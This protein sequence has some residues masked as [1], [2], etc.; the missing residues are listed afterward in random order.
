MRS[1]KLQFDPALIREIAARYEYE[2]DNRVIE[3]GDRARARGWFTR[4]EFIE[5]GEWKSP[6]IRSR[7]AR[8]T[9]EDVRT[10]TQAALAARDPASAINALRILHGVEK[11]VASVFLHLA[12]PDPYPILD[13]RALDA[14]GVT[15]RPP[16]PMSLWL[17]YVEETRRLARDCRVDM[18]TLDR[19]LWQWSRERSMR[20]RASGLRRTGAAA[21]PTRLPDGRVDVVILGCVSSKR[22]QPGP[23]KDLYISPLWHK[24]RAYA[25]ASGRP[26][27]IYSAKHGILAP[28]DPIEWYDVALMKRPRTAQRA[29]GEQAAAQLEERFG[30]LEGKVFEIHAGSAYA[31]SLE[32]PLRRR[33]AFLVNPVIGLSI[34]YQ[35]QWYGQQ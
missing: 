15:Q 5:I 3:L 4:D 31:N 34:G 11:P 20:S 28:D 29:K 32:V 16:V 17:D 13:F 10:A 6:R 7:A 22:H 19:A 33:G 21:L 12:H 8:N 14:F 25:E 35:L 24:R 23:A 30:R 9:A 27:V 2:D 18:R 1:L 26:W